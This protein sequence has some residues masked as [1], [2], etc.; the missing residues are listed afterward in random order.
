MLV[1]MQV[2]VEG[3]A[4]DLAHPEVGAVEDLGRLLLQEGVAGGMERA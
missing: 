3:L 4:A 2:A 1:K